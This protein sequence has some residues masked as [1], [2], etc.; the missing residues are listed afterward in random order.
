MSST[1]QKS[2]GVPEE[3]CP[4]CQSVGFPI[5]RMGWHRCT[6]CDGTEG[7]HP[8]TEREIAEEQIYQRQNKWREQ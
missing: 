4:T 5:S 6:F 7:G 3:G 8:P 2:P 1:C